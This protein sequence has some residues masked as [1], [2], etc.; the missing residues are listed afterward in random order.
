[1]SRILIDL[2]GAQTE[3]RF[4]GIGRYTVA[5]TSAIAR[6]NADHEIHLLLNGAFPQTIG[7]LR[8][9]FREL[10]PDDR[11]H[12]FASLS[13]TARARAENAWRAKASALLREAFI[14]GLDPDVVFCPSLVEGFVDDA[15]T[16]IGP[17]YEGPTVV[18][19]H[20]LIPL[21][22]ERDYLCDD[23]QYRAFYLNKI[24]E[25]KKAAA[26]L[27]I[28]QS[29]A[30]E[31]RELL[32]FPEERIINT[33][34]GVADC[35]EKVQFSPT[36]VTEALRRL[37]IRQPF[38]LYT[39]GADPRKNLDRLLQAFSR[40]PASVRQ[41]YALVLAGKISQGEVHSLKALALKLNIGH[42]ICF[43]G[44][45]SDA[46][47]ALLY[48]AAKAFI[49]PSLHEGFGLPVLEAL[50][51]G[52]PTVGANVSSIP[53]VV[54]LP[55]AL[56]DPTS[57]D[58]IAGKLEKVVSDEGFRQRLI[59]HA[60]EHCRRFS[61]SRSA[62]IAL[63]ALS[64]FA[65]NRCFLP[66]SWC[67][68][69]A[70][71]AKLEEEVAEALAKLASEP[72]EQDILRVAQA[73]ADNFVALE[74]Y[75][76]PRTLPVSTHWRIEGPFDSSYSLAL[77]NR[78]LAKALS[79]EGETVSLWSSEGPGDFEPQTEFLKAHSDVAR[80]YERALSAKDAHIVSRNMF[81]PRVIDMVSGINSL[82]CYAWEETGFPS[83][84]IDAFN[85]TLQ[86]VT[87]TSSHVKKI[88]RDAG[89][90]FP[91]AVVGNGVDHWLSISSQ[92]DFELPDSKFRFLH[93]SSCF[94]RKG[95]DILLESYGRAFTDADD[96]VL[97]IKTFPNPHNQLDML[98]E[99][100]RSRQP[101]Y[102]RV[103]VLND[104]FSDAQMKSLYERCDVLV[105]PSR[106][107]GFGLPIAEAALSGASI[108]TTGWSGQMDFCSPADVDLIKFH[109]TRSNSHLDLP[110]SMW[111]E[112]DSSH[113]SVLLHNARTESVESRKERN[114]RL[115]NRLLSEFKWSDV[116]KR[117]IAA[118]R[119][120]VGAPSFREP[121]VA[122]VSTYFQRCGIATYSNHLLQSVNLP[123]TIFAARSRIGGEDDG[124]VVRC[125]EEG[126]QDD[127]IALEG[128]LLNGSFDTIVVQFNY[129][130]FN[131]S[132]LS[133]L[134]HAL[135]DH[136]LQ[137]FIT[138]HS[139]TDPLHDPS[140]RLADLKSALARCAALLV[141]SVKDVNKLESLGLTTNVTL[142]PHGLIESPSLTAHKLHRNSRS[143]LIASYGFFL[144]NKGLPELVESL[145]LMRNEG[146]DYRLRL[147]NAEYP[148]TI[149][150][151]LI[152]QTKILIRRLKLRDSV[153]LH[154]EFLSDERSFML[155]SEADLVVYAYQETSESA[156]GAVRY[157]LASGLP[158]AV[159]PLPIF[160]EL[161]DAVFR[162]KATSPDAI[163]ADIKSILDQADR[164]A[165]KFLSTMRC[166]EK[167]RHQHSYILIGRRLRG[168]L[169]GHFRDR[170][171]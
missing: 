86:F 140:K 138:L 155:M 66:R 58:D 44:Y 148:A 9:K 128:H 119:T 11:I 169:I 31:A 74:R 7:A 56:F 91:I 103:A 14:A 135:V 92:A 160:D 70:R 130:F 76:R 17:F 43:T 61:W 112:P 100:V 167:W 39:G 123:V 98:L 147:I 54:G 93:V 3:S 104:Y 132:Y 16:D 59:D 20:D 34:E 6:R 152:D 50:T 78:E 65:A 41:K 118:A 71:L 42:Q 146:L 129:G 143:K 1:M 134:I 84:W 127:L 19:L 62:D 151:E 2:Q 47:L 109:F 168:L 49:F 63:D 36:E 77:V 166:A 163:A 27:S 5:L 99:N 64:R 126:D 142:F 15:I 24:A 141:H 55:E 13:P 121:K 133:R 80:M 23:V 40:L 165:P 8:D 159:T 82:H 57:V 102:P 124:N 88:L 97:V 101:R 10:V 51:C 136:G 153:E 67:Y 120:I 106:A 38:V 131:F 85:E 32:G 69:H 29:S 68:H 72:A 154:T 95:I 125:W 90:C 73:V 107:E 137:V 46:D 79:A 156:S 105:A 108:I 144:P 25:F 116:A 122:W 150:R 30:R 52:T 37:E 161:G 28:S 45:V 113:L 53:E 22:F 145:H 18:T 12:V 60:R 83:P 111:A 117:Q 75:F 157:G 21:I 110:N 170:L 87:V 171:I 115:Q 162:M 26:L 48:K 89:A 33:S 4:R 158:V 94:P 164:G 114:R 35:F 139:T 81:P 149:S 96:V